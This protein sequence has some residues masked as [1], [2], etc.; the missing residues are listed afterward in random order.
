[1]G[2]RVSGQQALIASTLDN[3]ELFSAWPESAKSALR[4]AAELWRF[5]KGEAVVRAGEP[6]SSLVVLAEG[7]VTNDRTWPNGK[8]MITAVLRT[9][10]PLKVPALWDGLDSQYGLTAREKCLAVL[11]P[12]EAFFSLTSGNISILH[13]VTDF[14]CRQLR[15]EIIAV[16]MKTV[17]SLR[18]QLA[19]T[20]FYHAQTSFHTT[21]ADD[22]GN[23]IVPID[24]TQDE[25]ASILGCSRQK[26]NNLMR[27][28][29]H[30]RIIRRKGRQVEIAST[31][32]L[33]DAMEEDEPI[34]PEMHRLIAQQRKLFGSNLGSKR[35]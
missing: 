33:L 19:L 9:G 23:Q 8:Y 2:T 1:L 28:M 5:E 12:R 7:S 10:W 34:P 22:L 3:V 27:E 14:I 29:E 24:V 31:S 16:Q 11:I 20:L 4:S 26:I 18:C 17:F 21:T 13:Q 6:V 15:H 35:A 30:D 25:F 32:L